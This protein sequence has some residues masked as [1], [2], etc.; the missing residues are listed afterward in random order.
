M[1]TI[2]I[3]I[4]FF[5]FIFFIFATTQ[6]N[7]MFTIQLRTIHWLDYS[8]HRFYFIIIII[9]NFKTSAVKVFKAATM[10]IENDF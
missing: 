10:P 4:F 5:K 1:E 3:I 6:E 7:T 9:V 2:I 8:Q